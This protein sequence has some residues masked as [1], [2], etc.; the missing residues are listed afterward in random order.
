[1][2]AEVYD[3][4]AW[5]R[6]GRGLALQVATTFRAQLVALGVRMTKP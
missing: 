3:P 5:T 1:M 2:E 6:V 4:E